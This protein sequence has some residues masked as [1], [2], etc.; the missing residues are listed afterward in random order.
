MRVVR[1]CFPPNGRGVNTDRADLLSA[2]T[3][4]TRNAYGRKIPP[5][6]NF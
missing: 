6:H 1:S 5:T 3:T 4:P 2:I